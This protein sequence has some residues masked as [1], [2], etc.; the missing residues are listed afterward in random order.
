MISILQITDSHLLAD[1]KFL[2]LVPNTA[3]QEVIEGVKKRIKEHKPQLILLTGDLSQDNSKASYQFLIETVKDLPRPIAWTPGNHDDPL[4]VAEFLEQANIIAKKEFVF[5]G[6]QVILL[7]SF[8]K[9]HVA[10]KLAEEELLFLEQE[11]NKHRAERV[12][13]FLHHHILPVGSKWLDKLGLKNSQ[14]FL[15]TIDRYQQVKIVAS[16]HVH[17]ESRQFRKEVEFITAPSTSIQFKRKSDK[18]ALDTLMPGY[19]WFN[20]FDDGSYETE[21]WRIPKQNSFIPDLKAK[22]Y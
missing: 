12:V 8:W 6:W 14:E 7:N 5:S 13:I 3:F 9:G 11:L 16:G 15:D 10:G 17:Q 19:R 1:N 21:I 18:F 4:E 2:G 20:L 22:G